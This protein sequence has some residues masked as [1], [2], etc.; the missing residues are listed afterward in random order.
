MPC[1][2]PDV[3]TMAENRSET[4]LTFWGFF[5]SESF[6]LKFEFVAPLDKLRCLTPKTINFHQ[7]LKN[8]HT[9]NLIAMA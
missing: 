3:V 9:Q 5:D 8:T 6:I 1:T 2:V 4:V 7:L